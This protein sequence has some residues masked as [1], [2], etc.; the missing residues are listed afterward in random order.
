MPLIAKRNNYKT[1][2]RETHGNYNMPLQILHLQTFFHGLSNRHY[3]PAQ[4]TIRV[5]L[6]TMKHTELDVWMA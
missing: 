2:E 5:S 6:Y 3:L 4:E 1:K